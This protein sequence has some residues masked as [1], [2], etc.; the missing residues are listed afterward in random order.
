MLHEFILRLLP[1]KS[2][3]ILSMVSRKGKELVEYS[4]YTGLGVWSWN[5]ELCR[6]RTTVWPSK[7]LEWKGWQFQPCPQN[8][9]ETVEGGNNF[10]ITLTGYTGV[11]R[12]A[13]KEL[14]R[15]T[16]AQCTPALTKT[17]THLLCNTPHS[18]KAQAAR[19]W[20]VK[21]VNH[22]WIMD[23]VLTW[24]WQPSEKYHKSGD[25]ILNEGGWTLLDDE[26][27]L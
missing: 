18:K 23:S 14:I 25:I 1:R 16:G 22:L 21:V 26:W 8:P 6:L 11:M 7:A 12:E 13:L 3:I 17:N 15:M 9:I 24:A 4:R 27:E 19:T 2:L 10:V 5:Y 20:G